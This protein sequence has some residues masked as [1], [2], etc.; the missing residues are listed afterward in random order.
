MLLTKSASI[1]LKGR[2]GADVANPEEIEL[3]DM[4]NPEEIEID[5][6]EDAEASDVEP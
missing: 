2:A 5:D 1:N 4:V 6:E 3:E